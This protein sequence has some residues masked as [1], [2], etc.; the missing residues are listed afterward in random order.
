MQSMNLFSHPKIYIRQGTSIFEK[1]D[2]DLPSPKDVNSK[3]KN[4]LLLPH[5][6]QDSESE[7]EEELPP[8]KKVLGQPT[9]VKSPER[10]SLT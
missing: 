2:K 8:E 9:S 3:G 7:F 1:S 4:V 6:L 10:G 5:F